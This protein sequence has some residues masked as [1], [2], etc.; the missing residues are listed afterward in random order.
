MKTKFYSR[1]GYKNIFNKTADIA[2]ILNQIHIESALEF[3]TFL[4][5]YNSEITKEES[6]ELNF[7]INEWLVDSEIYIRDTILEYYNNNKQYNCSDEV[8]NRVM[9]I[10][11]A[12]TLRIIEILLSHSFKKNIESTTTKCHDQLF[13][14]YLAI[15]DEIDERKN[16]YDLLD[17]LD[18]KDDSKIIRFHICLGLQQFSLNSESMTKKIYAEISKFILFEKWISNQENLNE[19]SKNYLSNFGVNEWYDLLNFIYNLNVFAID[20]YKFKVDNEDVSSKFFDYISKHKDNSIHWNEFSEIRKNPLLK[21]STNNYLILDQ[22]FLLDKFFSGI[23]HD[24][25]EVSINNNF[26]NFHQKLS[27]SFIEKFLLV[28][29]LKIIFEKKYIQFDEESIKKYNTKRIENIALPDYYIRNGNK[30]LLFECKNSFISHKSKIDLNYHNIEREIKDKFYS[31]KEKKKAIRQ[32]INFI[33][34]SQDGAYNFFDDN[35]KL[36][37]TIYYPIL[38]TTDLTLTSLGF[39]KLFNEFMSLDSTLIELNL[40]NRIKPLTIIHINDLLVRSIN[41][42]KLD[43]LIDEYHQYCK[44]SKAADSMISFSSYLDSIKFANTNSISHSS[45]E[46]LVKTTLL[47]HNQQ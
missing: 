40:K 21:L 30:N 7:I 14:L 25:L 34:L 20:N 9:I 39:N 1:I 16:S 6:S 36:K 5:K 17:M 28:R 33:K 8:D 27:E 4:N 13:L 32:L 46:K 3:F 31:N 18:F 10:N 35:K 43:L 12:T 22:Y 29:I 15:N 19:L 44:K 45:L 42:Q 24:I 47:N 2:E 11:K 26:T 37:N 38:I 23:Y 41:L